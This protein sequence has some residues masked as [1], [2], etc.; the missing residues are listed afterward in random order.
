LTFNKIILTFISEI[1]P[2]LNNKPQIT[3]SNAEHHQ[4]PVVKMAFPYNQEIINK[5]KTTTDTKWSATM[6]CFSKH[7]LIL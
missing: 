2:V 4:E 7:H 3:L 6:K 5:T 1:K